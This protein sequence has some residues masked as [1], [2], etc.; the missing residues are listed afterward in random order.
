M[1]LRIWKSQNIFTISA[2]NKF[3]LDWAVQVIFPNWQRKL[4]MC[5]MLQCSY[6]CL[7]AE[8]GRHNPAHVCF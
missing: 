1:L 6:V 5:E 7:G 8:Q 3:G 4:K 2:E